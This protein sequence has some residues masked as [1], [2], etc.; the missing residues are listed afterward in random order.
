MKTLNM[1]LL[2]VVVNLHKLCV[3]FTILD[4]KFLKIFEIKL[5]SFVYFKTTVNYQ[6]CRGKC[7]TMTACM[8]V[9]QKGHIK[10]ERPR[11]MMRV[12]QWVK[13]V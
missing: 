4:I 13:A 11:K 5:I 9:Q 2:C 3:F 12:L 7:Q 1:H 10:R 6:V 8:H